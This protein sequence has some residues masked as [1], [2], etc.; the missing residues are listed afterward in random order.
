M[1]KLCS[2]ALWTA[3][4]SDCSKHLWSIIVGKSASRLLATWLPIKVIAKK[5]NATMNMFGEMMNKI[6]KMMMQSFLAIAL[7][8]SHVAGS[9]DADLPTIIDHKR[10]LQ[11][12]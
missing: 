7:M 8:G 3:G 2:H 9:C 6:N 12:D 1:P 4:Q 5:D 11:S 10:L